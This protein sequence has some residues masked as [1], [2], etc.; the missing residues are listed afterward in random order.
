MPGSIRWRLSLG[1]VGLILVI[2]LTMGF[3]IVRQS[4]ENYLEQLRENLLHQA[5]LTS[6]ALAPYL[7]DSLK[8]QQQV[9]KMAAVGKTRITVVGFNGTVLADS[10]ADPA[11]MENHRF[12][13]EIKGAL[14]EGSGW[15]VRNSSTLK[16]D[17]LYVAFFYEPEQTVFRLAVPQAWAELS[18]TELRRTIVTAVLLASLAGLVLSLWFAAGITRPLEDLTLAAA[19]IAHGDLHKRVLPKGKDEVAVLGRTVNHMADSLEEKVQE[20]TWAKSRLESILNNMDSG[21]IVFNRAGRVELTNPTFRS[22]FGLKE[23]E[24]MGRRALEIIRDAR[25][26]ELLELSSREGEKAQME[27]VMGQAG[28]EKILEVFYAPIKRNR[29]NEG[30]LVV[31]HEIT[32]LRKLERIRSEF[33]ANVSHELRTPLTSVKGYAETLLDGALEDPKIS[34]KFVGIINDEAERLTRLI[35]DLLDLSR[36][37]S[38]A[39]VMHQTP[40]D[41]GKAAENCLARLAPIYQAREI[42]VTAEIPDNLPPVWADWDWLQQVLGNL[43]DN[44]VKYNRVG[45]EVVVRATPENG[46]VRFEVQ[47]TGP[48]IPRESLDRI[49]E[50]FYRVEKARSRKMGGTGLG[51]AIVKHVVESHGGRLGVDSTLGRGSTFWF[52]LPAAPGWKS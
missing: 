19:R 7:G 4:E 20:L 3:Y 46:G 17:L 10:E 34:R 33:V 43:V 29:D 37:E 30:T 49:F 48:G 40:V 11:G 41:P 42:K 1:Y 27:L 12:R 6:E 38:Q 24:I 16:Q 52:W 39:V 44:A 47:D 5:E 51:L 13:P 14:D 8:L 32:Q 25:F 23:S 36:L 35:N 26:Q 9:S 22:L 45:G 31:F 21:V 2:T 50:R 28:S 15:A 18:L